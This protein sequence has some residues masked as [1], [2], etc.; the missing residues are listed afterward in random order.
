[1]HKKI[2]LN[3]DKE[4]KKIFIAILLY[5]TYPAVAQIIDGSEKLPNGATVKNQK[6]TLSCAY[7]DEDKEL[8][9]WHFR[10]NKFTL[11]LLDVK[12]PDAKTIKSDVEKHGFFDWSTNKWS[13]YQEIDGDEIVLYYKPSVSLGPQTTYWYP[14][15]KA[16]EIE[17]T[18]KAMHYKRWI[19]K[20]TMTM[21]YTVTKYYCT[22][23]G[24]IKSCKVE[25]LSRWEL[26]NNQSACTVLPYEKPIY[27]F[28]F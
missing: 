12:N 3:R 11:H 21:N 23:E 19:S 2:L 28:G 10:A 17:G 27:K 25:N 8:P 18:V 14:D 6:I 7:Y 5:A 24:Y 26:P 1:M 9:F 4:I 16:T 15:G 13:Q 20:S 22:S